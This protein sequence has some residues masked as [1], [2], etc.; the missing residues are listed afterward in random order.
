MLFRLF[1]K[2]S[3]TFSASLMKLEVFKAILPL[4]LYLEF[5]KHNTPIT[6]T[7]TQIHTNTHTHT[8]KLR[9]RK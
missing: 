8:L 4:N 2:L 7:H 9:N 6:H 1:L 3:K 5:V